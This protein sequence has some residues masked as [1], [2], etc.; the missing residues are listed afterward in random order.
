[1][2]LFPCWPAPDKSAMYSPF[3]LEKN[4]FNCIIIN[5]LD[6]IQNTIFI[7]ASEVYW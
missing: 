1:M 4:K 3:T 5:K 7:K 2:L 6:I